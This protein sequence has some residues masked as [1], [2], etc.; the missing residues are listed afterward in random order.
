MTIKNFLTLIL[1]LVSHSAFAQPK[2]GAIKTKNGLLLYS[3][4]GVNSY[5]LNLE[6]DI[7]LANF[8]FIKQN[9]IW[10]QFLT[11]RKADFG[12]DSKS[13]LV[14]YMN[15]EVEHF[16]EMLNTKLKCS[17]EFLIINGLNANF[18]K[19]IN[20]EIKNE[21]VHTP[22]KAN[23]FLDFI[24]NDFVYRLYYAS[25]S[26]NDSEAKTILYNIVD[27]FKF[28]GKNIDL[29]RL[30]KNILQEKNYYED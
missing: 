29:E 24:H 26:G 2:D 3:N 4:A 11:T 30:Q 18:W 25:T 7:D 10:F 12:K 23:Y 17:N 14:N 19:F 1:I 22:V 6:G 28:Y 13:I 20:P 21:K 8:P 16:Q 27:S 9:N 15:W 5:T